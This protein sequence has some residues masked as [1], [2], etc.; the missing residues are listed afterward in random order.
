MSIFRWFRRSAVEEPVAP[1]PAPVLLEA[2]PGSFRFTPVE[3]FY[4]SETRSQYVAGL[5]YTARPENKLLSELVEKWLSEGKVK[6]DNRP[7]SGVRG[8]G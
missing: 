5:G 3:D 2:P 6:V 8:E 4:S 7:G 1:V